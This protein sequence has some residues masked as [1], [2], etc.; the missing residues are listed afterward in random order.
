MSGRQSDHKAQPIP[1]SAVLDRT[2]VTAG[3]ISVKTF[4]T[5][6]GK[7]AFILAGGD[8]QEAWKSPVLVLPVR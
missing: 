4:V 1:E 7:I 8:C 2:T 5:K 3:P 6:L